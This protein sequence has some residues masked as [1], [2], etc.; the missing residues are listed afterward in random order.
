MSTRQ[1][2]QIILDRIDIAKAYRAEF[3][4][5]DLDIY[6]SETITI[7]EW[8]RMLWELI[9]EAH[10]EA[11][12]AIQSPSKVSLVKSAPATYCTGYVLPDIAQDMYSDD[13]FF[14]NDLDS[15]AFM[16]RHNRF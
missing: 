8:S 3:G 10:S 5:D 9:E 16:V 6:N 4:A 15:F 1:T 11:L 14:L 2:I 7:C 12:S 13:P